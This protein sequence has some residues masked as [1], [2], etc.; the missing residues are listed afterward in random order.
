MAKNKTDDGPKVK[1]MNDRDKFMEYRKMMDYV[2]VANKAV[3]FETHAGEPITNEDVI[4]LVVGVKD[5]IDLGGELSETEVAD[6][7]K[8]MVVKA[9]KADPKLIKELRRFDRVRKNKTCSVCAKRVLF[10][11]LGPSPYG[12]CLR[13]EG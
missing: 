2:P 4:E 13:C 5:T 9:V 7:L 11:E 1:D 12:I 6:A 8:D 3:A 10:S